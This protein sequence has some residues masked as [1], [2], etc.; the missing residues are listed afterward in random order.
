MTR[1]AHLD[2]I[3]SSSFG[4][5]ISSLFSAISGLN[6]GITF[7]DQKEA[8]FGILEYML[9]NGKIKFIAPG[10]DCYV[11]SNN[12]NPRFTIYD[13]EA[14]WK[15]P[16][17]EI[18]GYLRERWPASASEENDLDLAIYFYEIPGVIW[19]KDSGELVAS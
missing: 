13:I 8:F 17:E 1:I 4:L 15:A 10:A 9:K 19:V 5:W 18:I 16:A 2:E 7:E 12:P 11:S 3:I 14:H 6:P